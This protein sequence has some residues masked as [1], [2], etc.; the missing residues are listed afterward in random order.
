M[1]DTTLTLNKEQTAENT[2]KETTAAKDSVKETENKAQ[3]APKEAEKSEKPAEEAGKDGKEDE[4]SG[5]D[6]VARVIREADEAKAALD[7]IKDPDDVE[8][9]FEKRPSYPL[10][11]E[12][13]RFT[14]SEG[15]LISLELTTEE[16]GTENFERVVVVRSFPISNPDEY[17][18]IREP[19]TK[20][21]GNGA[22]IGLIRNIHDFDEA[23]VN[24]LNEEL[25]RRYF[26]PEILHIYSFKEKFG[27]SYVDA[28]TSAGKITFVL[29]NP[30]SNFRTLEDDRVLIS[31]IDGN[32]F[33][34]KDPEKLDK[35]SL[36]KI[37]IYL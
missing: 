23:T 14:R 26:T 13:A 29:N 6:D 21:R 17:I 19:N 11:P 2:E 9:L 15:G 36:K 28:E 25:E 7:A 4:K 34:I 24:L 10:T 27:Y 33:V 20:R 16:R 22:E 31:D 8:A 3:K 35:A 37:E 30:Y 32:C 1:A 12:N 5:E 18:S